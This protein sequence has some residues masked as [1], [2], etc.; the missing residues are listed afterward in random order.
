LADFHLVGGT[1][2]ALR[3]AHR[4]SVDLDFFSVTDFENEA[5]ISV[6]ERNFSGF[7]YRSSNN[8][9]G[10]FGFIDDVKVD[11]V[12]NHFHPLI[13][14]PEHVEGIRLFWATGT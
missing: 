14:S 6:L 13:Q 5:I 3:Y 12:K 1:A 8:P 9:I 10:V 7:A 2:L 4:L 11:F